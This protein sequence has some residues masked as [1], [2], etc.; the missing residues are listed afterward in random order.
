MVKVCAYCALFGFEE[1]WDSGKRHLL[2]DIKICKSIIF[3]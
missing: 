2:G 1:T 3:K